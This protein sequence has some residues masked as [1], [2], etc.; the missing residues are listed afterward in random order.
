M[1]TIL[2]TQSRRSACGET[3]TDPEPESAGTETDQ[4]R[5]AA[6]GWRRLN[7]IKTFLFFIAVRQRDQ[8]RSGRR[9]FPNH[10]LPDGIELVR[11]TGNGQAN[12]QENGRPAVSWREEL[13]APDSGGLCIRAAKVKHFPIIDVL[14]EAAE[15]M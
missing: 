11:N 4:Q 10:L 13:L 2:E 12:I 5:T 3:H 15:G 7:S 8:Q 14:G 6:A 1:L 9:T